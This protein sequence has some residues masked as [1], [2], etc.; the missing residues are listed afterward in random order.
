VDANGFTFS[1]TV[2][3]TRSGRALLSGS[4]MSVEDFYY[5]WGGKFTGTSAP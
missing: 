3:P 1:P 2:A 5:C 4:L